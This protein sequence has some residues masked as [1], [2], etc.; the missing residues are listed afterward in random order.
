[1]QHYNRF[2]KAKCKLFIVPY[3]M[4]IQTD[5]LPV[6]A[7]QIAKESKCDKELAVVLKSLQ[8][9]HWPTDTALDLG[10][11]RK[12]YIYRTVYPGWLY[13]MGLKSGNS[14]NFPPVIA[15][16]TSHRPLRDEQNEV[17]RS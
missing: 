1:M 17:A 13:P 15:E 9:G 14:F 4:V 7:T 5:E 10:P 6:T 12:R 2:Y 11:F 16:R 3:C 8:H